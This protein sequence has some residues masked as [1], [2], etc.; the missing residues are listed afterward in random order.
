MTGQ[1]LVLGFTIFI[2]IVATVAVVIKQ[3]RKRQRS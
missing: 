3:N 1:D 2:A